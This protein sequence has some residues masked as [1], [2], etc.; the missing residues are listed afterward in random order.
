MTS[1]TNNIY[2][3]ELKELGSQLRDLYIYI[4]AYEEVVLNPE[5]YLEQ[6]VRDELVKKGRY[7]L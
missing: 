3:S 6:G 5:K 2:S 4:L 7:Y 1:P